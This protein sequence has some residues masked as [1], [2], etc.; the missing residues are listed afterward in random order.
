MMQKW[1]ATLSTLLMGSLLG[2]VVLVTSLAYAQCPDGITSLWTLDED[3]G[4][5]DI[6]ADSVNGNDG[7]GALRPAPVAGIVN[8]AQQFDGADTVVNVAA[9]DSFNWAFDDSFSIEYWIKRTNVAF[10]DTAEVVVGSGMTFIYYIKIFSIHYYLSS[11]ISNTV[12]DL[13]KA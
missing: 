8:G 3:I 2:V 10:S 4:D 12:C 13:N 11:F 5:G 1:R 6:F 9:D 7:L